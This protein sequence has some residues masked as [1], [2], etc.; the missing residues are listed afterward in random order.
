M[1]IRLRL[2]VLYTTILALT[3]LI[4]SG[5]LYVAQSRYTL[6][7][8]E[9]DLVKSVEPMVAGWSRAQHEL[10]WR[11]PL[12]GVAGN[13]GPEGDKARQVLQ[14]LVR[15]RRPRD[16][17]RILDAEGVPFAIP[18]NEEVMAFPISA[19]G[20]GKLQAGESWV[21]ITHDDEG[22]LLVYNQPVIVN[23]EV[24]GIV[25]LARSLADRDRALRSLGVTLLTGSALTTVIAFGAGWT[26]SGVTLRPIHRITQTAHEIGKARDFSSRVQ[27][28]G[29]N[30]ELGRLAMTFNEML[31]QL[32]VGYQ[33]VTRA[34]QVQRDFVADVSHELRT[35]LTT[36]RG[37]LALLERRPPL[38]DADRADI[39]DDLISESE[40][41]SRL[42]SDLLVLARSDAGRKLALGPVE[43][44]TVVEDVCR[45]GRLLAP[46]REIEV[47][48][49]DGLIAQANED[50]LK[51]VLLILL[52]NAIKHAHGP[53]SLVL[54]KNDR[55][56]VL[57]VQDAGPGLS[58]ELQARIF[59]RFY[60]SD[61]SRS[62]PG[63]GLGLS[64]ARA[65]TEAQRGALEVE[66]QVGQGSAFVVKLLREA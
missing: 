26:L 34:L 35:P 36:I 30:D 17:L 58:P 15:D 2:T 40:R 32:E 54:S 61:T 18:Q 12:P 45:Q 56:I 19:A 8:V 48:G 47:A 55:H 21:E 53:I 43:V 13:E 7:I 10:G 3:L 62:T 41:L 28:T 51:Q 23:G 14:P 31:S 25:Q 59:D 52:D 16:M 33:Q 9:K 65:L 5:V 29:P 6:A 57:R 4:F 44:R 46:D 20:L 38:P 42:V 49:P 39:L 27:H 11:A 66:S 50:A 22:R 63:F 1:S 60:R 24:T 37:N 64:I